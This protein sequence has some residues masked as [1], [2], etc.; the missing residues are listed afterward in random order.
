[1]NRHSNPDTLHAPLGNF[2]H[3]VEVPAGSRLYY[4]AGQVGVKPDGSFPPTVEEQMQVCY[5]NVDAILKDSGLAWTDVVR[6]KTLVV[7][8]EMERYQAAREEV[9][10][11]TSNPPPASTLIGVAC[12]ARPQ[13]LIEVEVIAAKSD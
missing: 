3:V 7:A 12:L 8:S 11:R 10:R 4:L 9:R 6:V 2:S 5:D 13:I 1:V